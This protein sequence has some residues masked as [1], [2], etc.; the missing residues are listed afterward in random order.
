M[1]T[2]S[3]PT[4]RDRGPC[5]AP[6]ARRP[7]VARRPRRRPRRRHR[8]RSGAVRCSSTAGRSPAP[9]RW[10]G[11]ASSAAAG[12]TPR[13]LGRP[14]TGGAGRR[15][16]SA[17]PGR[18]PDRPSALPAGRHVVGR[19][20]AAAVRIDDPSVEPHHAL[21]DV[22]PDGAVAV[23]QLTGRV[24][25]RVDGEPIAGP[26]AVIDGSTIELGSSRLRLAG[27]TSSHR[28]GGDGRGGGE[29]VAPDAPPHAAGAAAL[30]PAT[31]PGAQQRPVLG[32]APARRGCWPRRSRRRGR[33]SSPS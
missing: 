6:G 29:P 7:T 12:S 1:A 31:D 9:T 11:P 20:P 18:R 15:A 2:A 23:V 33:S 24:P 32:R 26:A 14:R 22:A 3:I 8:P 25:C 21:L 19:S 4:A 27:P 16:S 30:G 13:R 5:R 17:R 10:P 28:R